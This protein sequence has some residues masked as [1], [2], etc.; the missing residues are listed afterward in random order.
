VRGLPWEMC[1][2]LEEEGRGSRGAAGEAQQ[3]AMGARQGARG[4][5]KR[6]STT[7]YLKNPRGG[8]EKNQQGRAASG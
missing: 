1:A 2:E 6:E 3:D 8:A 7:G 5:E 4:A